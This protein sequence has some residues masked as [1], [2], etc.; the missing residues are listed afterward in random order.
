[1]RRQNQIR[2][3]AREI[4]RVV[5]VSAA[6]CP[7]QAMAFEHFSIYAAGQCCHAP[8]A[9]NITAS[10]ILTGSLERPATP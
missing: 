2:S 6:T 7:R 1:M 8:R 4:P 10:P 5:H 9:L 3:A